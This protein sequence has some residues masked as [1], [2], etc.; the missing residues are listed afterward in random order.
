[1]R[2]RKSA[3]VQSLGRAP[4][5]PATLGAFEVAG[6]HTPHVRPGRGGSID[7]TLGLHLFTFAKPLKSS[8]R[9]AGPSDVPVTQENPPPL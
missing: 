7:L 1:M 5:T 6:T 4:W 9:G 3:C 2:E 8:G